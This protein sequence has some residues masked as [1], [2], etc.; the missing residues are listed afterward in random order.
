MDQ[1]AQGG[2]C[3][4]ARIRQFMAS[5]HGLDVRQSGQDRKDP[6][7]RA[8]VGWQQGRPLHLGHVQE[9]QADIVDDAVERL[10]GQALGAQAP[11]AQNQRLGID[12]DPAVTRDSQAVEKMREESGLA[13]ARGAAQEHSAR[14]TGS[15]RRERPAQLGEFAGPAH[16]DLF[17][18][19]RRPTGLVAQPSENLE[20]L[21]T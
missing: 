21:A 6:R 16:K 8:D 11:T 17:D 4:R 10:V 18:A 13:D 5:V 7:E 1:L 14:T 2:K 9:M 15:A 3:A 19:A 12:G 20:Y